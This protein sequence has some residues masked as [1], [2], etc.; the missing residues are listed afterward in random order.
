MGLYKIKQAVKR[1]KLVEK[2]LNQKDKKIEM[3]K[4]E[5]LKNTGLEL[6]EKVENT[7]EGS[8]YF[9]YADFGTLLGIVRDHD[10]IGWDND[11]DYGIRV[12]ESFNWADFETY[13]QNHGFDKVRQFSFDGQIT[14]QTFK[15]KDLTVD[16]FG[17]YMYS[18]HSI[19]YDY[20]KKKDYFYESPN[21]FHLRELNY[22]LVEETVKCDFLG[23]QVTIP[24]NA[25]EL[26]E[27]IYTETWK[28][29]NPN[30]EAEFNP[31]V[32]T[33]SKF[34]YAEFFD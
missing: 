9:Y 7:L 5:A 17:Q 33:L 21:Q 20:Q 34:G 32:R 14:E 22:S 29:P 24:K 31:R 11:I 26:L 28:T 25:E 23:T 6:I 15:Y 8:K 12:T 19:C 3:R 30:W 27:S 16:F 4:R 13:M 10:F 2:Y 18:D 1:M